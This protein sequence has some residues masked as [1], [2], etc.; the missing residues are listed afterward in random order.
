MN[1]TIWLPPGAS[2]SDQSSLVM[3]EDVRQYPPSYDP[4]YT[5]VDILADFADAF[6]DAFAACQGA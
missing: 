1:L 3:Q 5:L 4:D 2:V 6:A